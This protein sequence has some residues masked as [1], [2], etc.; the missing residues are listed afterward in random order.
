MELKKI[1]EKMDFDERMK[2]VCGKEPFKNEC[3]ITKFPIPSKK[4]KR[5]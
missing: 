3:N 2:I 1:D 5:K 4:N